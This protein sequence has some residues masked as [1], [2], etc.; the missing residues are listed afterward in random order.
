MSVLNQFDVLQEV[1]ISLRNSDVISTTIRDVNRTTQTGTLISDSEIVIDK[2]NVK[3]VKSIT[4]AT[5]A[6][7][8]FSVDYD[9]DD[10]CTITLPTSM[11]GAYVVT[12]DYGTDKIFIGYPR[13]DL[14]INSFPRIAVEYIDVVSES[15]G[16]G[17]VNRNKHDIS[18]LVYST[19]KKQVR[20]IITSIRTWCINNQNSLSTL[21]LIKPVM[22]GPLVLA[23]EFAKFKDKIM[24]QNFDFAGLLQ[25]EV[26]N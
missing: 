17:N 19:N 21:R 13:S 18:I 1:V 6:V 7:T 25:Y 14:S 24:K 9:S 26:N 12:Y 3:N 16:F 22:M 10:E 2:P 5:V 4:V 23:G 11:S 15:G 8:G 20:D